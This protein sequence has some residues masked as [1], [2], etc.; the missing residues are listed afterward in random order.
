MSECEA[1]KNRPVTIPVRP[2]LV[3]SSPALAAAELGPTD[4]TSAPDETLR[5]LATWS[6]DSCKT[7]WQH[8][9]AFYTSACTHDCMHT[10]THTQTLQL[11]HDYAVLFCSPMAVLSCCSTRGRGGGGCRFGQGGRERGKGSSHALL[12]SRLPTLTAPGQGE[13]A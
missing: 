3:G 12:S 13:G 7:K 11:V 8:V 6:V 5:A 1:V 9:V 10:H 4:C 2:L